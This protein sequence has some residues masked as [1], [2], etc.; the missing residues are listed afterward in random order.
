MLL[1]AVCVLV[2]AQSS[3]EIPERLMNNP[4]YRNMYLTS[5]STGQLSRYSDSLQAGWSGDRI[6]VGVR[7]STPVPTGPGAH[8][9]S[10]T[11]GTGSPS[12]E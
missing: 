11:V 3:S 1:S 8:P 9:A 5:V 4:V 6:A 12:R 2:V 10:C 7:V